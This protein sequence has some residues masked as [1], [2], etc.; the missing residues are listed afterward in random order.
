MKT[1]EIENT[2][3]FCFGLWDIVNARSC[4]IICCC[5]VWANSNYSFIHMILLIQHFHIYRFLFFFDF[6]LKFEER[7]FDVGEYC[8]RMRRSTACRTY[9]EKEE[10]SGAYFIWLL[11]FKAESSLHLAEIEPHPSHKKR[12]KKTTKSVQT[13][14]RVVWWECDVE[15]ETERPIKAKQPK[16]T[17]KKNKIKKILTK[18]YTS[19]THISCTPSRIW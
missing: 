9:L 13:L 7:E 19:I 15:K 12:K 16:N 18:F 10:S 17:K 6:L 5:Y 8:I 1:V 11:R 2:F 3:I 4:Y 14:N